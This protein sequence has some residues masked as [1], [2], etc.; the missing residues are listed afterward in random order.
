MRFV[1]FGKKNKI[2]NALVPYAYSLHGDQEISACL[3]F[4]L[5]FRLRVL[6][7]DRFKSIPITQFNSS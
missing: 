2:L 5:K 1:L 7:G 4:M 6:Q 3:A